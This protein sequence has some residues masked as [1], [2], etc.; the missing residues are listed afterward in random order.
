MAAGLLP[1]GTELS[2]R[3]DWVPAW[4]SLTAD[5]RRLYARFMEAFA[6]FLSHTD[7]HIGRLVDFLERTG[8]LDRTVFIVVSDNGASSEG[9]PTGSVNDL[10]PW[11]GAPR[12]VEEA[13]RRI[14]EIGG[15]LC[16][17]NYPWGWT[18]AGNTP[19][20]R[21]KREVHEGGVAD[22]LIVHWPAG[23]GQTAQ[24]RRQFVHA[25]DIMPTLL[26]LLELDVPDSLGGVAQSPVQGTSFAASLTEPEAPDRH[27]VQYFEIFG[28]RAL[29][30]E[31]WKAVSFHPMQDTSH[32]FEEDQWELYHIETDP[33][34]CH[35]LAGEEPERLQRMVDR[36]WAEARTY[37]ALPLDNRAFSELVFDRPRPV[38]ERS[39]YVYYPGTA[40]V[41]EMVA[42]NVRNR[43]HRIRAVVDIPGPGEGPAVEGVLVAQG[44]GLG[45]WS[46]YLTEGRL[47]YVHNFVSLEERV[48]EADRAVPSGRHEVG[49]RFERTG[50]HRGVGHLDVD[51]EPCG[52][53]EIPRFTVTRFSLT[54]AGLTCGFSDGLP[55]TRRYRAPF[56]FTG[57]LREVVVEVDGPPWLDPES[58]AEDA[59][60]RQ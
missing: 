22:P 43:D 47:A 30:L 38:P 54:G 48:V 37:G 28:C 46:L 36:W 33:S 2:P 42:V 1:E 27:T 12:S 18:V 60:V 50:N 21:W 55:V 8:E 57:G 6:G 24:P 13:E 39:R 32:G 5:E 25:I 34:E 53:I 44:S 35:D 26:E 7:H 4:D 20:R 41:P 15:P 14:E 3:P 10:R 23:T 11:N 31:G 29:Y 49:F 52:V 40:V 17:N 58:E 59:M 45:G 56:R 51:G 9:G 16:H 19:F